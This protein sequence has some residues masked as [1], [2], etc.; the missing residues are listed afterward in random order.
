MKRFKPSTQYNMATGAFV[1]T[2]P[3]TR[4][5]RKKTNTNS[6][7]EQIRHYINMCGG[8]AMR[9]NVSGFFRENVGY[10]KSGS[11]VGVP[12]LLCV[13]DG[14][15]IGIE[16][17]TGKDFQ[18]DEQKEVE[19]RIKKAKGLYIIARDFDSFKAEFEAVVKPF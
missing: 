9:V 11:T 4:T 5:Q 8:Y 17:K 10:I 15:L 2:E 14:R 6:L 19:G 1:T 18:S 16:V 3:K 12:D 13:L 7:T